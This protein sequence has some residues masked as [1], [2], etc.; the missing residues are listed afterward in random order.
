MPADP[1]NSGLVVAL[2]LD[3]AGRGG[4][5][6][7]GG[8]DQP[9]VRSRRDLRLSDADR[10]EVLERLR[11]AHVQSRW[12]QDESGDGAAAAV[13]VLTGGRLLLWPRG[14]A[15]RWACTC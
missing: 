3:S 8:C 12:D 10:K 1:A 2:R 4:V 14:L 6:G 7:E 11:R 15:F 13:A 9:R 5:G